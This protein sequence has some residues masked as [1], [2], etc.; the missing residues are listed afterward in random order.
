MNPC[1]FTT[2]GIR[3]NYLTSRETNMYFDM[4]VIEF[5]GTDTSTHEVWELSRLLTYYEQLLGI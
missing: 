2:G 5:L 4:D 3:N 1:V